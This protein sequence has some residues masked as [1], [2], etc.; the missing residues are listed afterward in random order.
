MPEGDDQMSGNARFFSLFIALAVI[1]AGSAAAAE[2]T[3][4]VMPAP[5]A[6]EADFTPE[7]THGWDVSAGYGRIWTDGMYIEPLSRSIEAHLDG[8]VTGVTYQGTLGGTVGLTISPLYGG[9]Y[10]GNAEG[11]GIDTLSAGSGFTFASRLVGRADS[12]NLILMGGGGYSYALDR[13]DH[14]LYSYRVDTH[15]FGFTAGLKAQVA[16]HRFVRIIPF[17]LYMGGGGLYSTSTKILFTTTEADGS[18]DY[19]DAHLLGLDF[20]IFGVTAKLIADL[21]GDDYK[22]FTIQVNVLGTVRGVK[23]A[24]VNQEARKA[25]RENGS[26]ES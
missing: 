19:Q 14:D 25:A 9:M 16:F 22:S 20:N 23:T 6:P 12:Y 10:F 18:L 11:I 1:A 4:K 21:F 24:M 17:Y 8:F 13:E 5:P 7:N 3:M 15:L 26:G 2:L